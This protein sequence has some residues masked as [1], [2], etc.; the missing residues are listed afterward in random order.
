MVGYSGNGLT[1]VAMATS[2]HQLPAMLQCWYKNMSHT[3][4]M[5]IRWRIHCPLDAAQ[6]S[7]ISCRAYWP[8]VIL[9]LVWSVCWGSCVYPGLAGRTRINKK[10]DSV[11]T[12][13]IKASV[14]MANGPSSYV[15]CCC[16]VDELRIAFLLNAFVCKVTFSGVVKMACSRVEMRFTPSFQEGTATKGEGLCD[17]RFYFYL[18]IYAVKD[19][20]LKV[21]ETCVL[22]NWTRDCIKWY[23]CR[24]MG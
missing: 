5:D 21:T 23:S 9:G 22:F 15:I 24:F 8:T 17:P 10:V 3:G 20:S 19:S 6:C 12:A 13:K 1:Q 2:L 7:S 16:T 18:L 11:R 4:I 14:T